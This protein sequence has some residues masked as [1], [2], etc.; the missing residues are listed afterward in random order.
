MFVIAAGVASCD[1][2]FEPMSFV[3]AQRVLVCKRRTMP[4]FPLPAIERP[5]TIVRY[6][7]AVAATME[8]I[9]QAPFR[10]A[11]PPLRSG[12]YLVLMHVRETK[13]VKHVCRINSM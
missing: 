1:A 3:C 13:V 12:C 2:L 5:G 8:E 9:G 6:S 4:R 11:N 10:G 7:A